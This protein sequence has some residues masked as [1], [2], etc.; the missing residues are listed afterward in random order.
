MKSWI[1]ANL[2]PGARL[3]HA[4]GSKFSS[5]KTGETYQWHV[6]QAVGSYINQV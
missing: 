1:C 5:S 6:N 2:D 4:L 3:R